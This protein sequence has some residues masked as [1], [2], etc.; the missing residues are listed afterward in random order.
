[1]NLLHI[2][3]PVCSMKS[4]CPYSFLLFFWSK[5]EVEFLDL[6]SQQFVGLAAVKFYYGVLSSGLRLKFFFIKRTT[7][8]IVVLDI[9]FFCRLDNVSMNST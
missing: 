9:R 4:I 3:G 5:A 2:I 6:S 1:M 8:F 7:L